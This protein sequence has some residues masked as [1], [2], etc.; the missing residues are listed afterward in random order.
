MPINENVYRA[1]MRCIYAR[2]DE[3]EMRVKRLE[4]EAADD[5]PSD[6]QAVEAANKEDAAG[7]FSRDWDGRLGF[8]APRFG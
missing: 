4:P 8:R 1:E 3:L 5:D 6:Q 7:L 2:L